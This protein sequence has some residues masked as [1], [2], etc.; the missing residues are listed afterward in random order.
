MCIEFKVMELI[1][2]I[3][4]ESICIYKMEHETELWETLIII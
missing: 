1:N 2:I 4:G 3:K